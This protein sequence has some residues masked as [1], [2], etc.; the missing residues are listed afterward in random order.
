MKAA[1]SKLELLPTELLTDISFSSRPFNE[2]SDCALSCKTLMEGYAGKLNN[3]SSIFTVSSEVNPLHTGQP[4]ISKDWDEDEMARV[5]VFDK[6]MEGTGAIFAVG[7]ARIYV[8]SFYD[9][10]ANTLN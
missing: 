4:T 8:E 6:K 1:G 9:S 10:S 7:Q 5:W 2:F 3:K